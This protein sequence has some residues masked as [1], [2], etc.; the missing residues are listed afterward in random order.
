[1]NTRNIAIIAAI[2][3]VIVAAGLYAFSASNSPDTSKLRIST[4]T[5]LED[6]G[7]LK[8]LEAAY[9]KK[10]SGVDVQVVSGGT[11]IAIQYGE[12]GDVDLM[13]VHDKTRETKFV[14]DGFGTN[15]TEFAYNYFWIVG[16][17]D[18]PAGI[19][20]LNATEAF[21]K[22]A[23]MGQAN[24]DQVK[25]VSRGDDSGTHAREKKV[26]NSSG[27]DINKTKGSWYVESGKG[28]GDTLIIANEKNAY[29]I[30]DSGTFL[31]FTKEGKIKLV[32]LVTA[33]K[34]L[35]N[36]YTAIPVN[37]QKHPKTNVDG[38]NNFVNFLVSP[39]G[40]QIIANFGKDKFGQPLFT[41][42]PTNPVP[43]LIMPILSAPVPA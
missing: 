43:A 27:I 13:L 8:E 39:E 17:A 36:V 30:S 40:Q 23:E 2:V 42:V 5:S 7:L 32:P 11:G 35:L 25:F 37:P 6:T 21:K 19:K 22:I 1:M 20:G 34:D 38:A 10:Y 14:N 3:I 15:R 12:R 41:P 29:T 4:T 9:E 24:P 18:D 31:T 33:G 16:P 28:M 26:W